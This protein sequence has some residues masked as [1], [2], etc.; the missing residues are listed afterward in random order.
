MELLTVIGQS[1]KVMECG[2][3]T[4]LTNIKRTYQHYR[5]VMNEDPLFRTFQI[6]PEELYPIHHI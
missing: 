4:G 1:R 3:S 5:I 2:V 6:H